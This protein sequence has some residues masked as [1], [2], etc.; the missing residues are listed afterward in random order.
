MEPP[1]AEVVACAAVADA[2]VEPPLVPE[3][4]GGRWVAEDVLTAVVAPPAETVVTGVDAVTPRVVTGTETVGTVTVA[5]TPG[6]VA[7]TPGTETVTPGTDAVT[8]GT[9]T[10]GTGTGTVN[11]G[12]TCHEATAL[13]AKT[14]APARTATPRPAAAAGPTRTSLLPDPE[15]AAS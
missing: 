5:V 7:V 9:V 13:E 11:A 10:E 4:D 2:V 15:V 8:P 6:T 3:P 14:P 12:V 1:G